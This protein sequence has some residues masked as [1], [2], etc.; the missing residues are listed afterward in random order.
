MG[1]AVYRLSEVPARAGHRHG[2]RARLGAHADVHRER[3]ERVGRERP[4]VRARRPRRHDGAAA[5]LLDGRRH[6]DHRLCWTKATIDA[7]WQRTAR[8][9]RRDHQAGRHER[10]V[11]A[12]R[13]GRRDGRGH[14][15]RTR[16]RSCRARCS[17]RAST[18]SGICSSACPCKLGARGL[19][20]IIEIELT[21]DEDAAFK[22]SAGGGERA[23]RCHRRL[24]DRRTRG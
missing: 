3:A 1:Q 19:E 14:P 13:V 23:R 22:K 2:R 21:P 6:S 10:L 16:R 4:R 5:A 17:C 9:R 20:Q 12:W 8:R 7:I 15:A 24:G 18:A 11:R